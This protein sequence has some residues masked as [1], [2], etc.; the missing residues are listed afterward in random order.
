M[1]LSPF[2]RRENKTPS[3]ILKESKESIS[4]MGMLPSVKIFK[5]ERSFKKLM[6]SQSNLSLSESDEEEIKNYEQ[7]EK[8]YL[9]IINKQ[10]TDNSIGWDHKMEYVWI[11]KNI[12]LLL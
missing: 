12:V 11:V 10:N 4:S 2:I 6:P 3:F 7:K 5:T 8:F 1:S 9:R